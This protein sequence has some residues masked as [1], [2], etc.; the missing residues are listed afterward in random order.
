MSHGDSK[1]SSKATRCHMGTPKCRVKPPDVTWE[2]RLSALL[3]LHLQ[4]GLNTWLQW[5]WYRQQ[6]R[7]ETVKFWNLVHLVLDVSQYTCIYC[8]AIFP[9]CSCVIPE[10]LARCTSAPPSRIH[11]PHGRAVRSAATPRRVWVC[12]AQHP[13][14]CSSRSSCLWTCR[15][16][17]SVGSRCHSVSRYLTTS[18]IVWW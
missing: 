12:P 17:W 18:R 10:S 16:L 5:I 14:R 15:I 1:V 7:W 4:S 13:S 6:T 2:Y 8:P 3:H 11:W 9:S